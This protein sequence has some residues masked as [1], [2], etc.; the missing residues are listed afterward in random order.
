MDKPV[1]VLAN[2][3]ESYICKYNRISTVAY[4]LYKEWIIAKFAVFYEIATPQIEL[5]QVRKEDITSEL[6]IPAGH[7]NVP[8]FASKLLDG[9]TEIDKHNVLQLTKA[10]NVKQL[11]FDLLKLAFFDI[12]VANEDRNHNNYNLLM[13]VYDGKYNFYAIDHAA[14]FNHGELREDKL[15]ALTFEETLI[16]SELG[17]ELFKS[18]W[19]RTVFDAK[20]FRDS[21]YLY[22]QAC[23]QNMDI[24]LSSIPEQ[25]NIDTV[26]EKVKL[27]QSLLSEE[28]FQEAWITFITYLQQLT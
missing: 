8:C 1:K 27:E 22:R 7:F 9:S 28:W 18:R 24:I 3:F 10:S 25:W 5:L 23:M 11:R 14:C 19:L 26:S 12:W 6:G 17:H 4:R 15:T 20:K 13:N 16:Y 21:C 2:N